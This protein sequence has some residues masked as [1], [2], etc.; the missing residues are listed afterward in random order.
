MK[1]LKKITDYDFHDSTLYHQYSN[2][3][4]LNDYVTNENEYIKQ[5]LESFFDNM[6]RQM[7]LYDESTKQAYTVFVL[8]YYYGVKKIPSPT[9]AK[10]IIENLY[11]DYKNYDTQIRYDVLYTPSGDDAIFLSEYQYINIAKYI[12][13]HKFGVTTINSLSELLKLWNWASTFTKLDLRTIKFQPSES[14]LLITTPDGGHWENLKLIFK[15]SPE[16]IGLPYGEYIYLE[17]ESDKSPNVEESDT[18]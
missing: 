6:S 4:Q 12:L 1:M 15:Y 7:N 8:Q 3:K 14:G 10:A 11:D 9:R 13:N 17:T 2:C 16:L 5:W 18:N